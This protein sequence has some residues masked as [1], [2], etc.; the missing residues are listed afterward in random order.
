VIDV[1][2]TE[3]NTY[4][5]DQL[6][7]AV[8]KICTSAKMPDVSNKTVLLKPN[9]L[10]DAPPDKAL[11]TRSEVLRALIRYLKEEGVKK[12]YVGD[13]PGISGPHFLPRTSKIAEVIEQEEVS[14]ASFQS[15]YS[16]KKVPGV[17]RLQL[18]FPNL[19]DEV[20]LTFSVAKMK[21][22]QLMYVTGAVKNLFGCVVG[23]HKSACHLRYPSREAFSKML[24]GVY[25]VV[26]P[27]F[28]LMD[29]VIAM[30]GPG[31]AAG[32][33]RHM[34]LLLASTDATALDASQAIIMGHN[35]LDI[36]LTWELLSRKLTK[37]RAIEDISYPLLHAHDLIVEDYKRI[38]IEKKRSDFH[39]LNILPLVRYFGKRKAQKEPRPLFDPHIC[40]GCGKCVTICP[41]QTLHLDANKKVVVNYRHCIRCYC[42]HEV[43]P[44]DA[45]T[46]EKRTG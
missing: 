19:L 34:G 4:E 10:S 23:L 2:I 45:I 43:C 40:I 35:P 18:P 30:E 14:W 36:P 27:D 37:W 13:S 33:P 31:P 32:L 39:L 29:A 46:I 8:K 9:I 44:V 25:E 7:E 11:T 17:R 26:K 41:A 21:T 16:M 20:D 22:H 15:D 6:F 12:I 5:D 3:C 24:S 28:A 38:D 1:A 42:C